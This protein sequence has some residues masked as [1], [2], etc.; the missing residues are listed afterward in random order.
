MTSYLRGLFGGQSQPTKPHSE[1]RSRSRPTTA[2]SYK[3]P[4]PTTSES[5]PPRSA[6]IKRS[7][8]A[9]RSHVPSPLR[10]VTNERSPRP[11]VQRSNTSRSHSKSKSAS[12]SHHQPPNAQYS[13]PGTGEFHPDFARAF[14]HIVSRPTLPD[15][16]PKRTVYVYPHQLTHRF[17]CISSPCDPLRGL[18]AATFPFSV[19][20]SHIKD[21]VT[22]CFKEQ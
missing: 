14:V 12:S 22:S 21:A 11:A 15:P 17:L 2:A 6:G 4:K 5:A 16:F 13:G 9:T 7:Y 18:L 1:S 3:S 8:S 10:V 20:L 19:S